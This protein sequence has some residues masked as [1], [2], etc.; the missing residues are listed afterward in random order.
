MK[1]WQEYYLAKYIEKH[2]G[3]IIIG[4]LDEMQYNMTNVHY[5]WWIKYWQ[6]F[7]KITMLKFTP[8]QYFI[9]YHITSVFY[10]VGMNKSQKLSLVIFFN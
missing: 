9:L 7:G 4:N 8:R 6:T 1:Y 3:K 2:F 5:Y 10:L